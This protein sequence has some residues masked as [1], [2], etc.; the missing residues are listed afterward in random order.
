MC[1]LGIEPLTFCTANAMLLPMSHS[2]DLYLHNTSS[3]TCICGWLTNLLFLRVSLVPLLRNVS[4][5]PFVL[6]NEAMHDSFCTHK[7]MSRT[8]CVICTAV[9]GH[10]PRSSFHDDL[11]LSVW[12]IQMISST[13]TW[14]LRWPG[15]TCSV[16]S[17][18]TY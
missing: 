12:I 9:P 6:K 15:G 14:C 3:N 7:A 16:Y 4:V 5:I 10:F 17:P 11:S 2:L 8:C 13:E 18:T 1:S